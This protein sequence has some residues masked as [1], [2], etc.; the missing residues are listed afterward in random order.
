[1]TALIEAARALLLMLV[2]ADSDALIEADTLLLMLA[3]ADPDELIE[4]DTLMFALK[5][6]G[7]DFKL[8]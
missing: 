6:A 5:W 3:L 8:I 2:L 4:A 7:F 1:M